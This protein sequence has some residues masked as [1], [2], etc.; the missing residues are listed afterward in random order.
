M[1]ANIPLHLSCTWLVCDDVDLV[2]TIMH[3]VYKK[4]IVTLCSWI[5]ISVVESLG[6]FHSL[7]ISTWRLCALHCMFQCMPCN[8]NHLMPLPLLLIYT[9]TH[10]YKTIILGILSSH[11][12]TVESQ[13]SMICLNL[14]FKS[15]SWIFELEQGVCKLEIFVL[16]WWPFSPL[17]FLEY[18]DCCP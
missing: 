6:F 12:R 2:W 15:D 14:N 1:Y 7:K 13:I 16:K 11:V 9:H 18:L 10:I 5:S 17:P 3:S 4:T 8:Y